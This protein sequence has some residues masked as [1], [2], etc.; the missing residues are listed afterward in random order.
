MRKDQPDRFPDLAAE[1]VRLKVDVVVAANAAAV[2]AL[3]RATTT[4]SIVVASYGG[5]LVADGIVASYA[6]PGGNITG[7]TPLDPERPEGSWNFSRRH[8]PS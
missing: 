7:V 1:L 6:R 4:I 8:F 5:D 2:A 3:K